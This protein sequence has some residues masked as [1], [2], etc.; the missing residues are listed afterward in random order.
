MFLLMRRVTKALD[1]G[2]SVDDAQTA[3]DRLGRWEDLYER[4]LARRGRLDQ[5]MQKLR[6]E[7]KQKSAHFRE[8]MGNKM[9]N[10]LLIAQLENALKQEP[11]EGWAEKT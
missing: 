5:Q 4:L 11:G 8:L 10:N 9:I 2:Y 3:I 6:Q 7:G 1:Q